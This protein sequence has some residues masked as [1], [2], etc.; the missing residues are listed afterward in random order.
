MAWWSGMKLNLNEN[1][2]RKNEIKHG[3]TMKANDAEC[4]EGGD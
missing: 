2:M 3:D 1:K 4:N